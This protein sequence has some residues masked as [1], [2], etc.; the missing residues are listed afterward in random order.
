MIRGSAT[1]CSLMSKIAKP[2]M[3]QRLW[4]GWNCLGGRSWGVSSLGPRGWIFK[5]DTWVWAG[6]RAEWTVLVPW[7]SRCG[8]KGQMGMGVGSFVWVP[9]GIKKILKT[10]SADIAPWFGLV[11]KENVSSLS[12]YY[13]HWAL[14]TV[15]LNWKYYSLLPWGC[16]EG[17]RSLDVSNLESG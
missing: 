6:G 4:L 17:L 7:G 1:L 14:L 3:A 8:K 16:C 2:C 10:I 11:V 9:I 13:L 5:E 12:V 15:I